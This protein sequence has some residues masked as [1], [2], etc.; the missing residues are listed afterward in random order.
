[1]GQTAKRCS[2]SQRHI[3]F[4]KGQER[5]TFEIRD[6][7]HASAAGYGAPFLRSHQDQ[8]GFPSL[9]LLASPQSGLSPANPGLVHF[10]FAA[11]R[12]A[13]QVDHSPPQLVEHHPCGLVALQR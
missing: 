7:G 11:Q 9:Q 10:H 4:Q 5:Y 2:C 6:D 3:F 13:F 8:N 1:M 12:L